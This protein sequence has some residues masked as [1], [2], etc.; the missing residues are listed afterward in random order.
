[1]RATNRDE[2]LKSACAAMKDGAA[3]ART[4]ASSVG[5]EERL[6]LARAVVFCV[7]SRYW[8]AAAADESRYW[9]LREPS[10]LGLGACPPEAEE[11]SEQ[12]GKAAAALDP[13]EAGYRI[14]VVYTA[15]MPQQVRSELGAY[16]TP[17]ALCE[18]LLD[19]ATEAGTDWATARVLD[20][21]CGGGA[22]LAPVARRM[23]AG[24][25]GS[26][27][28]SVLADVERRLRGF[29]VDPFA[30][31]MSEVFLEAALEELCRRAGRRLR[32]VVTVCDSLEQAAVGE[33]YDLVVGNPPYGRVKLSRR[34]RGK[35]AASLFGHAN[36]YGVFTDQALRLARA[37]GLIAYVTPTSFLAG[38]Y[39]KALRGLL[40]REAPPVK[41]G[42]VGERK[43]VFTDVLQETLLA[44]YRRGGDAVAGTVDFISA[45]VDGSMETRCA[46]SFML[47]DDPCGP[48]LMPRTDRQVELLRRVGTE[49]SRLADLGYTVS[50]GP[51]VWN[52]HKDSLR[53]GGVRM[54]SAPVGG[55]GAARGRFRVPGGKAQPQAVLQAEG[56]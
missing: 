5:A 25:D 23:A 43:G 55:I 50:T 4:L 35:F 53:V 2:Q 47:P 45:G 48:W 54:L 1:M 13:V 51:L 44:V 42:F 22:F 49:G 33:G 31:W 19:M 36:L 11:L 15:M 40:A 8:K 17:P 52:R 56:G 3:T 26:S 24:L 16:Y 34:L 6:R 10:N 29:E 37:G 38:E 32:S 20:P 46:G 28:E 18:R 21:A 41:I 30:A 7:V 14:G 9:P 27:P 39:F 12:V